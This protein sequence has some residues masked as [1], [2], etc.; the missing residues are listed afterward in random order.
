MSRR[1]LL[2][3][4]TCVL[5]IGLLATGLAGLWAWRSLHEPFRGY[6]EADRIVVCSPR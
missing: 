5:V 1:A 3:T 6:T 2:W 4:I